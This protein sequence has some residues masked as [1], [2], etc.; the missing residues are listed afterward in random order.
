MKKDW[1]LIRRIKSGHSYWERNTDGAVG[2]ADASGTY[3]EDCEPVDKP[4]LLLDRTRPVML[5][6]GTCC[7]PVT[8]GGNG[9][10]HT[11][12][13]AFEAFWVA[14]KYNMHLQVTESW[15]TKPIE[16]EIRSISP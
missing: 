14:S 9:Q 13:A 10:H 16:F 4:P 7:V 1:T 5:G 2:I 15:D 11:P 8:N 12:A 3:P 6:S